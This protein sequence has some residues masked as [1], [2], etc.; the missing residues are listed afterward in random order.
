V[1]KLYAFVGEATHEDSLDGLNQYIAIAEDAPEGV[2]AEAIEDSDDAIIK[3]LS[4]TEMDSLAK[5]ADMNVDTH[6][7]GDGYILDLTE[8]YILCWDK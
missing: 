3:T 6:G 7:I 5:S 8:P 1:N 2:V 4:R